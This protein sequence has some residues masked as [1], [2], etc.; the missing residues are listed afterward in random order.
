MALRNPLDNSVN[1]FIPTSTFP[2]KLLATRVAS[3]LSLA[4]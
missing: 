1:P 2:I 3:L 4:C